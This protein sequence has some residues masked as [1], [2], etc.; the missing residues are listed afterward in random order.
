MS[1]LSKLIDNNVTH[2]SERRVAR[3]RNDKQIAEYDRL[4]SEAKTKSDQLEKEKAYEENRLSKSKMRRIRG[5]SRKTGFLNEA[6][7]DVRA[8]LG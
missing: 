3:E 4:K 8:E 2:S 7:E 6:G 1:W 5:G